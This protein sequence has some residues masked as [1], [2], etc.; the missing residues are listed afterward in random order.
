MKINSKLAVLAI[1]CAKLPAVLAADQPNDR[2]VGTW[3][4][5]LSVMEWGRQLVA[6]SQFSRDGGFST[7]GDQQVPP[8]FRAFGGTR[9]GPGQGI[10]VQTG[11]DSIRLRYFASV[12]TDKGVMIGYQQVEGDVKLAESGDELGGTGQSEFRDANGKV[13]GRSGVIVV[14]TKLGASAF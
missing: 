2:V 8:I 9:I 7:S 14:A 13:I 12:C 3:R 6:I 10:W 5:R 1:V 11:K 4:A